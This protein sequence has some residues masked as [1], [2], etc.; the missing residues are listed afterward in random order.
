M[1]KVLLVL[2]I[3]AAAASAKAIIT[4]L[5][6]PD[7]NISGLA[8]GDGSLWALDAVTDYVYELDPETGNIISSFY[9]YHPVTITPTG[10]A[11][12]ENHNM[13]LC[14]GWYNTN[15]YV[16]KYSPTG[17]YIGMIDMCGG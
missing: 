11:Y 12:S 5:D 16:Y 9:V 15:G 4:T 14:G 10:L 7:T 13:V 2:F 1:R 3:I 8:W 17:S 6:A